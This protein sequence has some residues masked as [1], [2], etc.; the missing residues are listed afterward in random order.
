MEAVRGHDGCRAGEGAMRVLLVGCTKE[1]PAEGTGACI[2]R[3]L[4]FRMALEAAGIGV[5]VV[6]PGEGRRGV[7]MVDSAVKEGNFTSGVLISPYPAE[8]AVLARPGMPLW[9][10]MN[11]QHPAEVQ[12]QGTVTDRGWEYMTRMLALENTLLAAGD[13][14]STPSKAQANAVM[15][16]LY[17]L[18]RLTGES[19]GVVP[20]SPLPH[21]VMPGWRERFERRAPEPGHVISTGSFN[22]WFDHETLFSALETAMDRSPRIRFTCTGGAIPFSPER[23]EHFRRLV[24]E[25]RHSHRFDL[26]G[27]VERSRLE[28]VYRSAAAAVY[29]DLPGGETVLG[30][31][32]RALDWIGSGIPVVCTR[33]AE[34][35]LEMD[36]LGLGA[37][38]PQQRPEALAEALLE[39]SLD[40][41][42]SEGIVRRQAEWSEGEGSMESIMEPLV[43][44]CRAPARL[45]RARAGRVTVERKDSLRYLTRI[46]RMVL[47]D[48]GV[49]PALGR[50]LRRLFGSG[51][52][53]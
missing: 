22:L 40:R 1:N 9:I 4:R 52:S 28:E 23:Y 2:A 32:T 3:T 41:G 6:A 31:R 14:F 12:L 49:G 5:E 37:A 33:G 24:S 27:W 20:V 26:L 13:R 21:C 30:A 15:G 16:E 19:S 39:V 43:G 18:G 35:S 25:S 48:Q 38:V 34:V 29:A 51:R 50:V 7:A 46:F 36:R 17:L 47:R 10:D 53:G 11:G 44:W 8:T 42:R 45:P